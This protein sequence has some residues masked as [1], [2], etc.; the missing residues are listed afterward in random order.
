[1][2]YHDRLTH[3]TQLEGPQARIKK[4]KDEDVKLDNNSLNTGNKKNMKSL[5]FSGNP[6]KGNI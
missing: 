1:M 3:T 5:N 6:K 4:I 2:K